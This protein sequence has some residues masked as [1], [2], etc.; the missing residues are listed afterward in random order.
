MLNYLYP[1][2]CPNWPPC[3]LSTRCEQFLC[4][5]SLFAVVLVNH[6][7]VLPKLALCNYMV[8]GAHE[9]IPLS[10]KANN[11]KCVESNLIQVEVSASNL[12]FLSNVWKAS[13][14][15]RVVRK[16]KRE[17]KHQPAQM[18]CHPRKLEALKNIVVR[19]PTRMPSRDAFSFGEWRCDYL[20]SF[21][22]KQNHNRKK[23][24]WYFTYLLQTTE[25]PCPINLFISS[26]RKW[27]LAHVSKHTSF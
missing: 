27:K 26:F 22:F 18:L 8:V 1:N 17:E 10:Y 16:W 3:Y 7:A 25:N 9:T 21:H 5:C 20:I 6:F 12:L 19:Q 4:F 14:L 2:V 15:C 13:D 11:T 23:S 24:H